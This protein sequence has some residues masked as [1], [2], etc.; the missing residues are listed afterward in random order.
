MLAIKMDGEIGAKSFRWLV[1]ENEEEPLHNSPTLTSQTEIGANNKVCVYYR[2][3]TAVAG[4]LLRGIVAPG[5][6]IRG[7][8][9]S[10]LIPPSIRREGTRYVFLQPQKEVATLPDWLLEL[11][12]CEP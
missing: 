4:R 6:R 8:G 5:M 1:F 12:C 9:D 7:E 2:W 11:M 3:P 10:V